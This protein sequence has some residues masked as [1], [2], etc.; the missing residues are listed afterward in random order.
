MRYLF[1][2]LGLAAA[3]GALV[4]IA[5]NT[6]VVLNR[7]PSTYVSFNL[8]WHLDA[9]EWPAWRGC[10]ILNMSLDEP[11]LNFLAKALAPA[12]LR[13]G[14]S[15]GDLVFYE[16]PG[17][18]CPPN[19]TFCLTMDRWAEITA[20]AARNDLTLAF[21]L[22]AMAGRLNKTCSKCPW[23]P[24]NTD[25]FLAHTAAAKLPVGLFE[26]GNELTPF[27]N[28]DTYSNDVL[29]LR[30]LINKYYPDATSRPRLVANDANPDARYLATV[31]NNTNGAIDVATWHMYIGYG[32]DPYIAADAWN[33]SF[34]NKIATVSAGIIDGVQSVESFAGHDLWVGESAMAW[35]SGAEG[36]TDTFLSS[37]WWMTALAGLAP[38]HHG[39]CR[40]TLV[41]GR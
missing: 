2:L 16:L 33:V 8:D 10:S 29:V 12:V 17:Q 14:G 28:V 25:A 13:V 15:Q 26:F 21:G 27:V 32:L 30:G 23:D 4:D 5:V 9:E 40:Q 41:G 1:N 3:R 18:P 35:H 34:I 6:S 11:N 37:P 19:T 24:T 39:F 22:N 20:F 31:L 36:V 38:S 7:I